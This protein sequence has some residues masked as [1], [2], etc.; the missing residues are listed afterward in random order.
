MTSIYDTYI[1]ALLADAT[2][3]HGLNP[4]SNLETVLAERMTPTLS[5]Y[6]SQNF[7]VVTQIES[8]DNILTLQSGFDATVWRQTATGKL[9]VSMRGTEPGADLA[10]AD[11]DLAL[12][13]NARDQLVDMINWWFRETGA[14]GQPV[15]QIKIGTPGVLTAA[16]ALGAG[17][18]TAMKDDRIRSAV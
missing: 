15:R 11:V 14:T 3:V 1:N 9:F 13:G 12:N 16:P 17:R 8:G 4:N 6:L 7:S 18:I 10:I 5:R 2:Y